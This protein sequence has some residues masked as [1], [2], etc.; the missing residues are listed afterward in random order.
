[1]KATPYIIVMLNLIIVTAA[2]K[3]HTGDD[4]GGGATS[5]VNVYVLGKVADSIIYWKNGEAN[6]LYK[7]SRILYDVGNPGIFAT[8]KDV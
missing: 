5:K 8:T 2:C 7:Q 1:M 4:E 6:F 3:K